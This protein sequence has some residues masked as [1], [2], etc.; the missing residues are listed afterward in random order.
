MTQNEKYQQGP[1]WPQGGEGPTLCPDKPL[2]SP[3]NNNSLKRKV[4]VKVSS[5]FLDYYTHNSKISA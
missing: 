2:S 3:D 4:K 5:F 1:D